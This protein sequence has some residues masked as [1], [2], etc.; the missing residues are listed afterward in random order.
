MR[1]NWRRL[2]AF[3][4]DKR[5]S[6]RLLLCAA[7]DWR[8]RPV[9]H[10]AF[11]SSLRSVP[12]FDSHGMLS[13]R[14]AADTTH[15]SISDASDA[16]ALIQSLPAVARDS[17]VFPTCS[18]PGRARSPVFPSLRPSGRGATHLTISASSLRESGEGSL[19]RS[20]CSGRG[21]LGKRERRLASKVRLPSR[22]KTAYLW[23][24]R[25]S[26]LTLPRSRRGPTQNRPPVTIVGD[27]RQTPG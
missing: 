11:A 1:C 6:L 27:P 15:V 5:Q 12:H 4:V 8:R 3:G 16:N 2:H 7:L 17:L 21:A 23:S 19:H 24:C 20:D 14:A 26:V 10:V 25:P 22:L 9:Q 13:I 18:C